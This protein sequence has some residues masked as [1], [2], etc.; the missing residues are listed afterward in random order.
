MDVFS[1]S[2]NFQGVMKY[3]FARLHKD[4]GISASLVYMYN[5]DDDEI[6]LVGYKGVGEDKLVLLKNFKISQE[7]RDILSKAVIGRKVQVENQSGISPV[8]KILKALHTIAIPILF[9]KDLLGILV[10]LKTRPFQR[11]RFD[12]ELFKM[13]YYLLSLGMKIFHYLELKDSDLLSQGQLSKYEM[14]LERIIIYQRII[15][16]MIKEFGFLEF[17]IN[18]LEAVSK[19]IRDDELIRILDG[20]HYVIGDIF[21][22]VRKIEEFTNIKIEESIP[23]FSLSV[24]DPSEL[25]DMGNIKSK[26]GNRRIEIH[27]NIEKG[28]MIK[29]KKDEIKRAFDEILNNVFQFIS[30]DSNL[31]ISSCADKN[32]FSVSIVYNTDSDVFDI[33]NDSLEPFI[34]KS[35]W[36]MGLG[37]SIAFSLISR[38]R[39]KLLFF[40]Q[41]DNE[42]IT[43]IV[44]PVH[45]EHTEKNGNKKSILVVDD[46]RTFVDMMFEILTDRGYIVDTVPNASEAVNIVTKKVYDAMICDLKLPD[47]DG[48]WVLKTLNRLKETKNLKI[49]QIILTSGYLDELD[50][51]KMLQYG[52]NFSITKPFRYFDLINVLNRAL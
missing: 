36:S 50:R 27:A 23:E 37:F 32:Y 24:F 14:D 33:E 49:P 30:R 45:Y 31:M 47:K 40:S 42:F 29:A 39:G 4:F 38:N 43:R 8:I 41:N 21:S 7:Q 12:T 5:K 18:P 34:A 48:W 46:D 51:T 22:R 13:H 44:F 16:S 28:Y 17:I 25:I 11:Y 15:K 6:D 3:F 35:P 19:K 10:I 2:F 1:G 20:I 9:Q 52:V 26:A